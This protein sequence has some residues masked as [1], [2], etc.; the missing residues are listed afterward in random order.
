MSEGDLF[1]EVEEDLRR[2]RFARAWDRY[3]VYVIA[4]AALIVVGVAGASIWRWWQ[5]DRAARLGDAFVAAQAQAQD[6]KPA[7]AA[8]ALAK[9]R[10][11]ATGGYRLLALLNEAGIAAGA[12]RLDDAVR[13]YDEAAAQRDPNAILTGLAR[14]QGATLRLDQAPESEIIS[15]VGPMDV[16]GDAWRNSARELLGLAAFKAG[17]A[18]DAE[19]YFTAIFADPEAPA[20]LRSRAEQMLAIIV[21]Q[22]PPAASAPPG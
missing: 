8:G 5:A 21:K 7:D 3:G 22:A 10:G 19:K 6:G 17:R 16:Q 4:V 14:I 13:L 1:R 20:A 9:L 12:G 2:E 15:R 18:A 11:E